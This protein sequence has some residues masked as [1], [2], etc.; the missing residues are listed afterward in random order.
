MTVRSRQFYSVKQSLLQ[1]QSV[2]KNR[3]VLQ[4]EQA[5]SSHW[6][7]WQSFFS[8]DDKGMHDAPANINNIKRQMAA[9]GR[10]LESYFLHIFLSCH[11][12]CRQS[13]HQT[14]FHSTFGSTMPHLQVSNGS[15]QFTQVR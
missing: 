4:K 13:N 1:T 8:F 2:I 12:S 15:T 10:E 6:A 7:G 14:P 3:L 9:Q 11:M 5:S